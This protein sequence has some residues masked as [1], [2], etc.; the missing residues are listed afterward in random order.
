MKGSAEISERKAKTPLRSSS[1]EG[2]V[3]DAIAS[4]KSS[5]Q[6]AHSQGASILTSVQHSSKEDSQGSGESRRV[7]SSFDVCSSSSSSSSLS[8]VCMEDTS[9]HCSSDKEYASTSEMLEKTERN[10]VEGESLKIT[11][12]GEV[13]P[14]TGKW[15]LGPRKQIKV[16]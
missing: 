13:H 4:D 7:F 2:R 16:V 6:N 15:V 5:L 10:H 14:D 8:S 11:L 3:D 12:I 1:N 9:S